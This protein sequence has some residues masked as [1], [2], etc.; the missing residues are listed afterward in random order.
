MIPASLIYNFPRKRTSHDCLIL[1]GFPPRHRG[2]SVVTNLYQLETKPAVWKPFFTQFR[3]HLWHTETTGR[4]GT[5]SR[6]RLGTKTQSREQREHRRVTRAYSSKPNTQTLLC[7]FVPYLH[8]LKASPTPIS[9]SRHRQPTRFSQEKELGMNSPI[10]HPSRACPS[11]S[12]HH[13]KVQLSINPRLTFLHFLSP[14]S[15]L[16]EKVQRFLEKSPCL[17]D[18]VLRLGCWRKDL[19]VP[20]PLCKTMTEG[21]PPVTICELLPCW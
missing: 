20:G 19:Q 11:R 9:S 5:C 12:R 8:I 13:A 21:W 10:K 4:A 1:Q 2:C 16:P 3:V 14:S 18:I 7:C 15:A 6:H 17:F